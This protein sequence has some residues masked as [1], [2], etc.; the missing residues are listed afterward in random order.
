VVAAVLDWVT[1]EGFVTYF[2]KFGWPWK[3]AHAFRQKDIVAA[4]TAGRSIF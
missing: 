1:T 3:T 4:A 2:D